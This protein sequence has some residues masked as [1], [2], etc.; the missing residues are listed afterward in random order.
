[1]PTA[2]HVDTARTDAAHVGRQSPSRFHRWP[3][4]MPTAARTDAAHVGRQSPSRFHCRP[5]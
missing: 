3:P 5:P 1:M 2:D 4:T